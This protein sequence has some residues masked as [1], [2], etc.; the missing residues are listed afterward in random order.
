MKRALLSLA[1][2]LS[3]EAEKPNLVLISCDDFGDVDLGQPWL[4]LLP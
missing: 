2:A 1:C 3:V 4:S